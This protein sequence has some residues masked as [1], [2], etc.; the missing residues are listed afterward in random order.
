MNKN[1]T[2]SLFIVSMI[3]VTNHKINNNNYYAC[4]PIIYA[5]KII[6]T[7]SEYLGQLNYHNYT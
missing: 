7:Y 2:T 5:S 4:I 6:M 3:F 1:I